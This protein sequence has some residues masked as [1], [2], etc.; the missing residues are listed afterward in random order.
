MDYC[1]SGKV[2]D[3]VLSAYFYHLEPSTFHLTR[4]SEPNSN[5]SMTVNQT[6]FFYFTGIWGDAQY[7]DDHPLQKTVPHFGLKRFVSGPTGP[8]AKQLLRKGLAPDHA[9]QRT[10][11]EWAVGVF[12]AWYPCCIRGPRK[13]AAASI[14]V[15]SLILLALGIRY[16]R[17]RRKLKEY[18]RV[19]TEIPMEELRRIEDAR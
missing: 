13:W 16:A 4:L 2:W 15:G 8:A 5:E 14:V 6:S 10:W 18:T 11:I 3:P 17:R 12:M 19:E 1:D 9:R 7:P